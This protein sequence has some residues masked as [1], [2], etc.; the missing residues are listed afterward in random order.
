MKVHRGSIFVLPLAAMAGLALSQTPTQPPVETVERLDPALDQLVDPSAQI[1]RVA[2]GFLWTEGPV[3]THSGFLLFA[4]IRANSIMEWHPGGEPK[5][6]L[7]PSGY[8]GPPDLF[9]G[10]EPG[11]DGMTVDSKGRLTVAGHAQ[12]DV[13]RLESLDPKAQVTILADTYQ[14]KRLNSPNDLVY[15]SDGS[16]YFTDPPYGLETQNDQDPKKELKVNGVYLL[17]GARDQKP[18]APPDRAK[19]RLLIDDLPRPNGICFSPDEKILYVNDTQKRLWM[20][21]D[22]QPDGSIANGKVLLD[23]STVRGRGGPDGMKV[24]RLGNIY[25]A[26]AG[27]VWIISPEGKHLGT[28]HIPE[29]VGNVGWG[30]ADGKGLYVTASTSV[31]RVRVKVGGVTP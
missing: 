13:W 15:K 17:P 12:R 2:T 18:G 14:G 27:G 11:S 10:R 23:A 31:Y 8:Q 1:E 30:D 6:F 5:V 7:H 20:R 4:A 26:G 9:K 3:W 28:L 16:L 24:D 29:Q 21:Y 25:S 19:L 22:V